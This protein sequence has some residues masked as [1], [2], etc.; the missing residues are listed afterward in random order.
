MIFAVRKRFDGE[1]KPLRD[2]P[3]AAPANGASDENGAAH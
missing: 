2:T 1:T 3:A